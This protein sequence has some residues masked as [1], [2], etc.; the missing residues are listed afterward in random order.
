MKKLDSILL[1]DDD[2][3]SNYLSR[4]LLEDIGVVDQLHVASNGKEALQLL[5]DLRASAGNDGSYLPD[6]ILLDVNM[7]VMSGFEFIESYLQLNDPSGKQTRIVML[8]S[9]DY[10][11]DVEKAR[12]YGI[13]EYITKPLTE[14]SLTDLLNRSYSE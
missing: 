9:S 5:S 8:T 11:R 12:K 7:P 3:A 14:E 4:L 10:T 2:Y 1:I 13:H 6:L